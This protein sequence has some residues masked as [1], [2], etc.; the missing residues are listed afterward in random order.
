MAVA[1]TFIVMSNLIFAGSPNQRLSTTF[2]YSKVAAV[3]DFDVAELVRDHSAGAASQTS[4]NAS[5]TARETRRNIS[6]A[7]PCFI[8][9]RPSYTLER[10]HW[11]NAVRN[12]PSRKKLIV[13]YQSLYFSWLHSI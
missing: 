10:A 5:T 13:S 2:A 12:D 9:K 8:T 11:V 7:E 4:S 1:P 6:R 3:D